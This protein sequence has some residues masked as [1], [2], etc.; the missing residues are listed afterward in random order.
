MGGQQRNS[1][2]KK[3]GDVMRWLRPARKG[4]GTHDV[5]LLVAIPGKGNK[6]RVRRVSDGREY[7][8]FGDQ[9]ADRIVS[10]AEALDLVGK[11]AS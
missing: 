9:L 5:E 6:W 2:P 4:G 3:P 10:L 8:V 11:D 1:G 7:V